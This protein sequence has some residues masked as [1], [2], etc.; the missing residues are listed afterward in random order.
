M[1]SDRAPT[2]SFRERVTVGYQL[3][4]GDPQGPIRPANRPALAVWATIGL[5]VIGQGGCDC[6]KRF[7]RNRDRDYALDRG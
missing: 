6:A 2:D 7:F 5:P 1:E 4:K 3:I